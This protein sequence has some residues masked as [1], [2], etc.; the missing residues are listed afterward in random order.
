MLAANFL[1][2]LMVDCQTISIEEVNPEQRLLILNYLINNKGVKPRDLG[3]TYDYISKVRRGVAR[4]GDGLLCSMLRLLTVE[5]LQALLKGWV[6]EKRATLSDALRVIITAREDPSFR[7]QFLA[8]LSR[9]L[10]DYVQS[11]GKTWHVTQEDVEAYLKALRLRN[12]SRETVSMRLR[13]LRRALTELD[14]TLS[15]RA[16]GI[17]WLRFLR[18]MGRTLPGTS[19]QHSSPSSRTSSNPGTQVYSQCSTTPSRQSGQGQT[20]G[21]NYPALT[22]SSKYSRG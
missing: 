9:Y 16:L 2:W 13:Y 19:P 18:R 17:T 22:S 14:Y 11:L 21:L 4:V 6:P 15:Q 8:L 10:G 5:E 3:V 7:E 20:T 12:A 1:A